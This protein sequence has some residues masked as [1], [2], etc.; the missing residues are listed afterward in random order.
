MAYRA[1]MGEIDFALSHLVR[2]DD[3]ADL[4]RFAEATREMRRAVL[5][6][7]ARLCDEVLAPLNAPADAEGARLT[8]EGVRCPSGFREAYGRIAE[9]GWVG[10]AAD[11]ANGG[12]GLPQTVATVVNEMASGACLALSLVPLLSVGQIEAIE[13]HADERL[14]AL[15]LPKLVSGRWTGTMNLTE[16]QAGSDLSQIRTVAEPQADG[17]H[18]LRGQKVYI[19]FGDHDLAENISHLVLARLPDAPEG[20]RGLSLFAAPKFLP[21]ADGNPG[22]PNALRAIG[23]ERKM[24]IHASPTCVMAYEGATAWLVGEPNRGLAGM[25]TMMNNARLNVGVQGLGVGEAAFQ[26]AL[27]FARERRQGPTP[28]GDGPIGDHADVRRM[29][30][31]MRTRLDAARAIAYACAVA[32]D[33]AR[34]GAGEAHA[35]RW[36]FLTPIAKAFCT[37]VGCEVASLAQQVLGGAGYVHDYGVEQLARD[38]RIAPIYEGTNGI[39]AMD[40]VGRKLADGGAAA[41]ALIDRVA[42]V[43]ALAGVA[44]AL[45]ETTDWMLAAGTADRQAGGEPYLRA[46]ALALG[47]LYHCRAAQADPARAPRAAWFLARE[48]VQVPALCRAARDGSETLYALPLERL[49][50]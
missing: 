1:P 37:D 50:A 16:A 38:I 44:T 28:R 25:F 8:G 27:A 41:R 2:A 7:A 46:W 33:M 39:Q 20:V 18:R 48:A 21:D 13:A 36:A 6:E 17:S 14:K 10:V 35:A 3:L 12:M 22:A 5:G 23:I 32:G 47:A 45:R 31:T 9:G 19:T 34:G 42:A 11:P 26:A 29:L 24:G 49:G 30:M 15:F 4:P 43:D 40:L